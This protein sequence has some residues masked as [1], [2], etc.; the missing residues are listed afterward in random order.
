M[1]IAMTLRLNSAFCRRSA[2]GPA[3]T[4]P[5]CGPMVDR[6][7]R[8]SMQP[9]L[10]PI[11]G[12]TMF[13]KRFPSTTPMPPIHDPTPSPGAFILCPIACLPSVPHEFRVQQQALYE[14]AYQQAREVLKP[15]ILERDL[16]GVWN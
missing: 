13:H 16:L 4:P 7:E 9:P 15:S 1:R 12:T 6:Q 14:W 2:G 3:K 5:S 8:R 11:E 10:R